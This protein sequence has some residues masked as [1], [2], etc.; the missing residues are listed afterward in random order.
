VALAV[1]LYPNHCPASLLRKFFLLFKTW[2]WPQPVMLTKPHDAGYG[3]P[4]WSPQTAVRQ[5]APM[6][7]PA[8]PAMNSTLSV[9]RQTLQIL[10]GEFE[11]GFA[12]VDKLWNDYS[13]NP[14]QQ[15][16]N[17]SALFEP[18]DFFINYSVRIMC[19]MKSCIVYL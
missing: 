1:Q 2:R 18:S 13:N 4:V 10:Q 11:R 12:I 8:Y 14:G 7:T 16:L 19:V 6:I 9:S 5:V 3:L 17:W 15:E